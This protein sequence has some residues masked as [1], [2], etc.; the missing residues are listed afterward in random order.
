MVFSVLISNTGRP[1][2]R[3]CCHC[4]RYSVV[5]R[6][7]R[8]VKRDVPALVFMCAPKTGQ[9]GQSGLPHPQGFPPPR[10][11]CFSRVLRSLPFRLEPGMYGCPLTG[12]FSA[13]KL[14]S[15]PPI[16][17]PPPAPPMRIPSRSSISNFISTT[18]VHLAISDSFRYVSTIRH[19]RFEVRHETL[20]ETDPILHRIHIEI[21]KP[22]EGRRE[23]VLCPSRSVCREGFQL[24]D[25]GVHST[26]RRPALQTL[27]LALG[28]VVER[29]PLMPFQALAFE[30]S[31]QVLRL[32]EKQFH[33]RVSVRSEVLRI[34][35]REWIATSSRRAT[36]P[37]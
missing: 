27:Q 26:E 24:G 16:S 31:G 4:R 15:T 37:T 21:D 9:T 23:C 20:L 11:Y 22:L 30:T 25:F 10:P 3:R 28:V 35:L 13:I 34:A 2:A 7:S 32:F 33:A 36:G 12:S 17:R 1:S 14:G 18:C 5:N 6:A 29:P 8:T 19:Y